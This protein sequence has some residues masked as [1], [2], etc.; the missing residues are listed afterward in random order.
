LLGSG[1]LLRRRLARRGRARRRLLGGGLLRGGLAGGVGG[2]GLDGLGLGAVRR[3]RGRGAGRALRRGRGLSSTGGGH[4]V[5]SSGG[6]PGGGGPP[7][8]GDR[9]SRRGSR[10]PVRGPDPVSSG[11]TAHERTVPSSL[12]SITPSREVYSRGSRG[13]AVLVLGE[14][15]IVLDGEHRARRAEHDTARGGAEVE[16]AD[17]R[18]AAQPDDDQARRDLLDHGQE[19]LPDVALRAAVDGDL[20]AL[21]A[22]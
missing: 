19:E 7:H 4:R 8:S 11:I 22:G 14:G 5:P 17:G 6:G 15:G 13:G 2:L 16:L 10:S 9:S 12:S 1:G 20:T 21:D 18:L 3:L